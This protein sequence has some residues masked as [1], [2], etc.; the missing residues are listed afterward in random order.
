MIKIFTGDDRLR[1]GQE[2]KRL[3]GDDY[4]VMEG[5]ELTPGDLASAMRGASLFSEMRKIL[6]RDLSANKAVFDEL[7]MYLDTP[8]EVV[9]WELKLDKRSSV[10]KTL[11][12]KVEIR[13][14]NLQKSADFGVVF[15]IYRVAKR[16]G[17]RAVGMLKAIEQD[18]DP[19]RFAGL[20]ISQALK[21][22]ARNAGAKEK[23]VL[24][25]LSEL[26]LKLKATSY[27]PWLLVESSLLRLASL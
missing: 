8:H 7:P 17:R 3:L 4:E 12:D 10:Y 14:F 25:E 2:I 5:V 16:D 23:R 21:D 13:E 26:D 9:I 24:R 11:K 6:I 1:A 27:S 19:I 15:D 22:Y 18:E 20:L